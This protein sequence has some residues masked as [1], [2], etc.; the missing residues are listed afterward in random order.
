VLNLAVYVASP[1]T[2]TLQGLA[3]E[4]APFGHAPEHVQLENTPAFPLLA[5]NEIIDPYAYVPPPETLPVP[6]G[7]TAVVIV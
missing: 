4:E 5:V 2:S 7:D 1:V 6:L 3:V